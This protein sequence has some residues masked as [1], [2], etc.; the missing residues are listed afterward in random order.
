LIARFRKD[1]S[2]LALTEYLILL[3]LLTAVVV[4]A[5][6]AFG[7]GLGDAWQAWADWFDGVPP[8]PVIP[9]A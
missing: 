4:L 6:I 3:G 7:T 1:E 9:A 2:G 8:P 5:V